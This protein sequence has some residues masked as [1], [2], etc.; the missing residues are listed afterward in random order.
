MTGASSGI[1]K[2]T[3]I[4]L[5]GAGARVILV[6]RGEEKLVETKHEIEAAGGRCWMYTADV[7]DL[8]SCD[9]LVA[10]VLKEHGTLQLSRQQTRAARSAGA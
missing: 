9:A 2:A 7:S 1:G 4:K 8:A 6:A 3:A 5:A 10:R